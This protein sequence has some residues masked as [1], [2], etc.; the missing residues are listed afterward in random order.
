MRARA[1]LYAELFLIVLR[2]DGVRPTHADYNPEARWRSRTGGDNS[3]RAWEFFTREC[4]WV[5]DSETDALIKANIGG[6]PQKYCVMQLCTFERM[7]QSIE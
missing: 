6:W 1:L 2:D 3:D 7:A 4:D 5:C